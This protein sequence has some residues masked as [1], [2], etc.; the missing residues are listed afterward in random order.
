MFSFIISLFMHRD[1]RDRGIVGNYCL[2]FASFF[3]TQGWHFFHARRRKFLKTGSVFCLFA[4][5]RSEFFFSLFLYLMRSK[6]FFFGFLLLRY[7]S[8]AGNFW[9][10][11]FVLVGKSGWGKEDKFICP[12]LSLEL[13]WI[14]LRPDENKFALQRRE[15][16]YAGFGWDRECNVS[17]RKLK[18]GSIQL[19]YIV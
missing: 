13:L 6:F 10:R 16:V 15:V 12:K 11:F 17:K 9:S 4:R 1:N 19:F 3:S 8:R 14:N 18:K 5:Q 7:T 2:A